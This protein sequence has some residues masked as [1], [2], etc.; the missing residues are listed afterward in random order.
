MR[1]YWAE[2]AS[3]S[4]Q[5]GMG[6]KFRTLPTGSLKQYHTSWNF[7]CGGWAGDLLK[8]DD[9]VHLWECKRNW[10]LTCEKALTPE[11]INR[12][13]VELD[14][15]DRALFLSLPIH[16]PFHQNSNPSY[17]NTLIPS[18]PGRSETDHYVEP[19]FDL[20][21]TNQR[22]SHSSTQR[23]PK[24]HPNLELEPWEAVRVGGC[25]M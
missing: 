6:G 2:Q 1:N 25:Q 16:I 5:G 20:P 14:T 21:Y 10:R 8:R 22:R 13:D 24:S 11:S 18:A 12:T 4:G 17:H 7:G 15:S 19:R 23:R 3:A 9:S